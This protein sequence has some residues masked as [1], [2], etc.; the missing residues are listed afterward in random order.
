M[1]LRKWAVAITIAV[2]L[3]IFVNASIDAIYHPPE[4]QDYCKNQNYGQY[5]SPIGP[6]MPEKPVMAV[7]DVKDCPAFSDVT[8][9]EKNQCTD[10]RGMVAYKRDAKGCATEYYCEMCDANFQAAQKQHE[11]IAFIISAILGMLAIVIGLMLPLEVSINDWIA[12]GLIIGGLITIFVGTGRAYQSIE[13]IYRP[14]IILGELILVIYLAYKRLGEN[15]KSN[16]V[17]KKK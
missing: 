12:S 9:A 4:Y 14:L 5:S 17:K 16:S 11:N 10:A 7:S 13:M 8:E 6:V 15:D 1:E 2:L 3:A